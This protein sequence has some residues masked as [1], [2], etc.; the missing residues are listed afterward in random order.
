[1]ITKMYEDENIDLSTYEVE[2]IIKTLDSHENISREFGL[3]TEQVYIIKAH[4][5]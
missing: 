1:M 4:F 3:S 2:T 5:R